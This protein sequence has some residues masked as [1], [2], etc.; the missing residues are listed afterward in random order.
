MSHQSISRRRFL[1][2]TAGVAALAGMPAL[3]KSAPAFASQFAGLDGLGMAALVKSGE[4]TAGELLED[5]IARSEA[6]NPRLN[7][8]TQNHYAL[9]R[10]AAA[11]G[12]LADGPFS[13]VPFLLKDLGAQLAGTR[14]SQGARFFKDF[15]A[16]ADGELVKRF[17]NAGLNIF[18][19]SASSEFGL[20]IT[21][22]TTLTGITRNPWNPART[23]GGSSGGAAAAVA[24]GILP[25]AH[26]SDGG[27][28]IRIPASCCG[29]FGMKPS[30][31]RTPGGGWAGLGVNHAVS[32]SVRDSAA[33]LDAISGP[34]AGARFHAPAPARPYLAEAGRDPGPLRV[35]FRTADA[36]GQK[37]HPECVRAVEDTAR[38][39]EDMGH[40]VTEAYPEI[41]LVAIQR[42]MMTVIAV[43]TSLTYDGWAK[44]LGRAVTEGDMEQVT[45]AYYQ[46]AKGLDPRAY[47]L[48]IKAFDGLAAQVA[49]FMA[50]YDIM[51]STT[52]AEPPFAFGHLHMQQPFETYSERMA[53]TNP[54]APLYNITG[55]PAMSVPLHWT[56]GL[57]D[58]PDVVPAGLPVG[59]MFAARFGDE[60]TLYQLAGQLERAQPWAGKRP[61]L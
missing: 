21:I 41:D 5:A 47:S 28:S 39:L 35:A 31:G 24:A 50:D 26:A 43:E 32:R 2:S 54:F 23:T 36:E 25:I 40:R 18:G 4:V 51:L 7:F 57:G 52:L 53:R 17:K 48:A 46:M 14:T 61:P 49:A 20:T 45:W 60:A 6:A 11:G 29:V 42:A 59:V 3:L 34:A 9:A 56:S 27:G 15:T 13:G 38:L 58:A 8:L 37:I 1:T 22:E 30:R 16:P 19:K 44:H 55:Q 12:V 33:M 10:Q